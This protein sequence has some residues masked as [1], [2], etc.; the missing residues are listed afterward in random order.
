VIPIPKQFA[1]LDEDNAG[2][3]KEVPLEAAG[4][5]LGAD[6]PRG[7]ALGKK[8]YAIINLDASDASQ[9]TIEPGPVYDE[10]QIT[11][12]DILI[13]DF[14]THLIL[15][16]LGTFNTLKDTPLGIDIFPFRFR[17]EPINA[18]C[19]IPYPGST[20]VG[21]LSGDPSIDYL[22]LQIQVRNENPR[23][24]FT[25]AEKIRKAFDNFDLN[26]AW[27]LDHGSAPF[28]LTNPDDIRANCS[29][30]SVEFSVSLERN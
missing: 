24:A 13:Q 8:R 9:I 14:A 11:A 20:P 3:D 10:N 18:I 21:F 30:F 1:I 5:F 29:R 25:T 22:A 19:V 17:S 28:N 12:T 27:L 4:K 23:T 2:D 7:L 16:G 26:G 6:L 15:L